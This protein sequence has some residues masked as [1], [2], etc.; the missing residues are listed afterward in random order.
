M[1]LNCQIDENG[2]K[3]YNINFENIQLQQYLENWFE[4]RKKYELGKKE[5][6]ED[7]IEE[8]YKQLDRIALDAAYLEW[9]I[10]T[11]A[12]YVSSHEYVTK[13][14]NGIEDIKPGFAQFIW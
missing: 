2:K 8:K 13:G 5:I 9:K 12:S 11:M 3:T 6:E 4:V 10:T 7:D 14:F 1:N